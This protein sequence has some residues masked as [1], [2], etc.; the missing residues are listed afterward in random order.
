MSGALGSWRR[1]EARAGDRLPYRALLDENVVLLRDGSV[2]IS[3]LVPGLNFETADTDEL[4]AHAAA[5]EVLLRSALDARFVL[6]HHVIRRQVDVALGG[7]F[8]DPLAAHVDER[9]RERLAG[10]ALFVNDQFLTLVRRPARGK[11][12]WADRIGRLARRGGREAIAADPADLRA[13]R[14]AA[15]AMVAALGAYGARVLGDYRSAGVTCSEVLE[16]LSALYNGEMRPVRRP[17]ED[18]DIGH[19][20][21]YRRVSFGLDAMEQRGAG[22][23]DF[24]AILSLK[25][26]PDSTSP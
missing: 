12:G 14:A 1:K 7:H 6:Y 3:L 23:P 16:L 4:N 20:L 2:M 21:P 25:D 22:E 19:M 24:A 17:A 13:L 18:A 15:M 11:A 26:Y 5:R 9:W 8:A 10:G